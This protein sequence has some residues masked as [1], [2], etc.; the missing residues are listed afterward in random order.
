MNISSFLSGVLGVALIGWFTHLSPPPTQFL[1]ASA[2]VAPDT[3][4]GGL[5]EAEYARLLAPAQAKTWRDSGYYFQLEKVDWLAQNI[6]TTAGGNVLINAVF[7]SSDPSS[8]QF[9]GQG[10]FRFRGSDLPD[11]LPPLL[12]SLTGGQATIAF[13]Q[14]ILLC[15][16]VDQ[17]TAIGQQDP[18]FPLYLAG[19][20]TGVI[21]RD[22]LFFSTQIRM[23]VQL[24]DFEVTQ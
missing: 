11:N 13:P 2:T 4:P 1:S 20:T 6:I 3:F 17:E 21:Y 7:S 15:P 16:T 10:Q 22:S 14:D 18:Y 5:T 24:Q 8:L 19:R 12:D 9:N 23:S